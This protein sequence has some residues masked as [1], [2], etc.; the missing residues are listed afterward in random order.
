VTAALEL[1]RIGGVAELRSEWSALA[2]ASGNPFLTP[3]WAEVWLEHVGLDVRTHLFAARRPDG[4]VA[5][6]VPLVVTQGRYVRKARFLG[7]GP[8][9]ELGPVASSA[10]RDEAAA[11]LR[12][13]LTATKREWD[14]FVGEYLA[15]KGW[16][17]LVGLKLVA[18]KANPVLRGSWSTWDAYL[19]TRSSGFRQELRRKERRLAERGLAYRLVSEPAE[20]ESALDVLFELHRAR[21]GESASR[22]FAGREAFQRAFSRV[23]LERGWLRLNILELAGRPAAVYYGFR[24]GE[25]EWSYQ[26]GRDPAEESSSVGL[27][28]AAHA[29]R[30]A[31]EEGATE[32][33]LGPGA[34]PYKLRFATDDFLLETVGKARGIRGLASLLAA[35]RRRAA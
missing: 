12:L 28:V 21:W 22:W 15:G 26:F 34:Q 18:R 14:V 3:E 24:F 29:V 13:A 33:R 32:F 20:L 16:A 8:A 35:R 27:I 25:G 1:E 5:A 31:L 10:G 4:T 2:E 6:I 30:R 19:A 17:S 9:N 23:A 7:F 11:A